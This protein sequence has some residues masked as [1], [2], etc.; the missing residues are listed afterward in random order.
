[1]NKNENFESHPSRYV[2]VSKPYCQPLSQLG[3]A[4]GAGERSPPEMKNRSECWT[5][6]IRWLVIVTRTPVEMGV[7]R[8][9]RKV[10]AR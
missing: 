7:N 2:A 5:V 10:I 3:V 6:W 8:Y 4:E 1:M 9:E